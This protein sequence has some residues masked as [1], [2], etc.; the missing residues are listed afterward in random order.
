MN[1][2][3]PRHVGTLGRLIIWRPFELIFFNFF[4]LGRAGKPFPAQVPKLQIIF[5]EILSHVDTSVY[6]YNVYLRLF[7]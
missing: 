2:A 3:G 4:S 7:Q 5:K 1:I 6:C